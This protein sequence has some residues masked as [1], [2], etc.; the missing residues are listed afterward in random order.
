MTISEMSK[1]PGVADLPA[2]SKVK[3]IKALRAED[4]GKHEEAAAF[5]DEAVAADEAFRAA[6]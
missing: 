5:L 6:K 2:T 1:L 4:E 3:F